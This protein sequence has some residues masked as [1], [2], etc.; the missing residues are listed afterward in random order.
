MPTLPSDHCWDGG[1]LDGGDD[2][3][4]LAGAAPVQAARAAAEAAQVDHDERVAAADEVGA[5]RRGRRSAATGPGDG[6]T[7]VHVVAL[8]RAGGAGLARVVEVRA[9]REDHRRLLVGRHA[10]RAQDVGV[11]DRAVLLLDVRLAPLGAG[12]LEPVRC[13][14]VRRLRAPRVRRAGPRPSSASRRRRRWR[15]PT[16]ARRTARRSR[17]ARPARGSRPRCRRRRR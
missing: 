9:D 10:L 8:R 5:E 16:A 14:R 15:R 3:G 6:R 1:P 11:Q 12:L 17:R 2:V 7:G 13:R 4:L